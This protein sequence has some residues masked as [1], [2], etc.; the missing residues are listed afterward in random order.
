MPAT[1]ARG[2]R[3]G[4]TIRGGKAASRHPLV[5]PEVGESD[6]SGAGFSSDMG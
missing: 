5:L 3:F 4:G 6:A 1:V 2:I